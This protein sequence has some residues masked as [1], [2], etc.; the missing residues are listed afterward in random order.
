MVE[1]PF[2]PAERMFHVPLEVIRQTPHPAGDPSNPGRANRP[3]LR[4][5]LRE[6]TGRSIGQ[7]FAADPAE[8]R[9]STGW[10]FPWPAASA[11]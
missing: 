7:R 9:H 6:P 8:V 5:Y 2:E 11:V 4:R 10:S 1:H 3:R